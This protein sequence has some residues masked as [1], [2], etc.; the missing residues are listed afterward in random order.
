MLVIVPRLLTLDDQVGNQHYATIYP[1]AISATRLTFFAFYKPSQ[2]HNVTTPSQPAPLTTTTF[3]STTVTKTNSIIAYE[4]K[5]HPIQHTNATMDQS[6]QWL[7]RIKQLLDS[8]EEDNLP[9]DD[10]TSVDCS[11]QPSLPMQL[12]AGSRS[13]FDCSQNTEGPPLTLKHLPGRGVGV[14]ATRLIPVD[15]IIVQDAATLTIQTPKPAT[16]KFLLAL[17]TQYVACSAEVRKELLALHAHSCP[18]HE[19]DIRSLLA[20][21]SPDVHFTE[22]QV[23]LIIRLPSIFETNMFDDTAP[24]ACSLY[25]Q[26]SRFNHSCIP[27]CD[28]GHTSE[29]ERPTMTIRASRDIKPDEELCLPY[30]NYYERRGQRMADLERNWGFVCS[31][32][33][34][35]KEDPSVDTEKHEEMLA[36][37]RQLREDWHAHVLYSCGRETLWAKELDEAL[38][39]SIRRNHIAEV[40]GD[41]H[42]CTLKYV[43]HSLLVSRLRNGRLTF[44][45]IALS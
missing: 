17:V 21:C 24:G 16:P 35:D 38:D 23:N 25:L 22:Q 14:V 27:N 30:V 28:Y 6:K 7:T 37:Y 1:T 18:G 12:A 31:C 4:I 36:E 19:E 43:L 26:A 34:C 40:L 33:A 5:K 3:Q 41:I 8:I 32:P 29:G 20:T 11:G 13:G 44:V 2:S 45:V 10:S 39:R 9:R 42:P 15:S